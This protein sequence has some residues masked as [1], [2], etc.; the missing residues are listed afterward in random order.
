VRTHW[1]GFGGGHE[2]WEEL[3]EFFEKLRKEAKW[4]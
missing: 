3:D 2:L 1:Q 4:A